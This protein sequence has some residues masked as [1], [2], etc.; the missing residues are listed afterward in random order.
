[1]S[2][3]EPVWLIVASIVLA[4]L[5]LAI[6]LTTSYLKVS[7]VLGMM[8]SGLGAQNVPGSLATMAL[9][10]AITGY[11]MTPTLRTA[12]EAMYGIDAHLLEKPFSTKAL[13]AVGVVARPFLDFMRSH[14]SAKETY[15]V[16]HLGVLGSSAPNSSLSETEGLDAQ[17]LK[18]ADVILAFILSEL[19]QAFTMSFVLL[20]PFLVIDIVVANILVGLGMFMVSPAM[21]SLPLK[22]LVFVLSDGWILLTRGLVSSYLQG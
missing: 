1:M 12:A 17:A 6:G 7:I 8:K 4:L 21:I 22:L 3:I 16:Q 14:V 19:R 13:A 11:V 10:L 18:P 5:P 15:A 9:S 2:G 20:L